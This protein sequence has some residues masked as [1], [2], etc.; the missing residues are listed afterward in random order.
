M[1][2]RNV[3]RRTIYNRIENGQLETIKEK[4]KTYII[5]EN[6]N[7]PIKK[8]ITQVISNNCLNLND[9]EELEKNISL[10][11]SYYEIL[12]DFDYNFLKERLSS[13]EKSLIN[14]VMEVN[15]SSEKVNIK[16]DKFIEDIIKKLNELEDKNN[17]FL[18]NFILVNEQNNSF[19]KE[20]IENIENK[21]KNIEKKLEKFDI[22]EEK[23]DE[24]I[25]T[26]DSKKSFALF[27]K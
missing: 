21:F 2:S 8:I 27:K 25:K 17:N 6:L 1:E 13:I 19:F 5:K 9:L 7:K 26:S 18:E 16:T 15:K 3:S 4:N 22:L 24:L 20:N 10:L 11:K 14:F 23:F 12:K